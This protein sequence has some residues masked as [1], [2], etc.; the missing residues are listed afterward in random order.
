METKPTL[1]IE[2]S[3][4]EKAKKLPITPEKACRIWLRGI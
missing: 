4:L 3:I 2:K 1:F